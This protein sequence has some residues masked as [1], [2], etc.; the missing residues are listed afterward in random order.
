MS[1]IQ[2]VLRDKLQGIVPL[3]QA[4]LSLWDKSYEPNFNPIQSLYTSFLLIILNIARQT[5]IKQNKLIVILL[6][7][8]NKEEY[9]SVIHCMFMVTTLSMITLA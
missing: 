3:I 9:L 5:A 1:G 2:R 7:K 8:L 4:S 6:R